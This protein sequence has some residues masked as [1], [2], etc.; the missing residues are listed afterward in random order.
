M[1]RSIT[2]IRRPLITEKMTR[3]T[4]KLNQ[5]AFEVDPHANKIE[6]KKA[7]E[8]RFKVHVLKVHTVVVPGKLKRMGKFSGQRPDWK[9]AIITLPAGE[10]IELLENA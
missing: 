9:K 6:I 3:L 5:Y 8:E 4:E 1:K 10:K 7:I 2:L